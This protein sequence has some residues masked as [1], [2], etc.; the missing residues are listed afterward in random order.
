MCQNC[1]LCFMSMNSI[2]CCRTYYGSPDCWTFSCWMMLLYTITRAWDQSN[3]NPTVKFNS[4]EK[5]ERRKIKKNTSQNMS[6]FIAAAGSRIAYI[7]YTQQVYAS[8][9][10]RAEYGKFGALTDQWI[11]TF[12]SATSYIYYKPNNFHSG[13]RS[14]AGEWWNWL[15]KISAGMVIFRL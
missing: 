6:S 13:D 7:W 9:S 11:K 2:C 14:E 8:S 15:G 10:S 4:S 1:F 12:S 5:L 3:K